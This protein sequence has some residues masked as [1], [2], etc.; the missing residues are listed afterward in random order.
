MQIVIMKLMVN[1]IENGEK[2]INY[3]IYTNSSLISYISPK[4]NSREPLDLTSSA[5]TV[6]CFP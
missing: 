6:V 2:Y 3:T 5:P 1:D 4:D